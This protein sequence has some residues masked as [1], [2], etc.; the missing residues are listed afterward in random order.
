MI[1]AL[2]T[3]RSIRVLLC[4]LALG[5]AGAACRPAPGASGNCPPNATT[6][7]LFN[8]LNNARRSAG[9]APVQWSGALA[10]RAQSWA[11]QMAAAGRLM[12]SS[13]SGN[14]GEI[15]LQAP[16]SYSPWDM[17]KVWWSSGPHRDIMLNPTLRK[18]GIGV[19]HS[20]GWAWADELF[21]T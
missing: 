1:R 2:R 14:M 21:S 8:H 17:H 20:R 7:A 4:V 6:S 3:K 9:R 13:I 18:V 12:H 19:A 15:I 11:G 10:C 16:T 5:L